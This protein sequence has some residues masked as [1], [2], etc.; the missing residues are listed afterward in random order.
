MD[1]TSEFIESFETER[2]SNSVQASVV[3]V[4]QGL[5]PIVM[6]RHLSDAHFLFKH[7][8]NFYVNALNGSL[9]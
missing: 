5:L 9:D 2:E 6:S 8:E 3:I 4:N 7:N 1:A